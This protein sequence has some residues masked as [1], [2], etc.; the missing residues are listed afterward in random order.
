MTLDSK[1]S[2]GDSGNER[3]ERERERECTERN[4]MEN[5]KENEHFQISL[6]QTAQFQVTEMDR[7]EHN[8]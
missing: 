2:G 6:P 3:H 1:R 5:S 4:N 8:L 7:C